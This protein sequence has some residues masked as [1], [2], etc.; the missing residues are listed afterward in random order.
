MPQKG[1]PINTIGKQFSLL[2]K[3]TSAD[4]N[5]QCGYCFYHKRKTDPYKFQGIHRMSDKV[6]ASMI[7]QYLSFAGPYTS[8]SWQG[9][10]P[11]LMGIDFFKKVVE[12]QKMYGYSGQYIGNSVQTNL[13]LIT[14]ELAEL[15][16][17]YNFLV[18]VS[19]DGPQEYHDYYRKNSAKNGSFTKVME[20]IKILQSHNVEF[21]ILAVVNNFTVKKAK[22]TYSFFTENGF[23]FLQ[24]IPAVEFDDRSVATEF[25][26]T[27]EDY[28]NFL[29]QL[30]D[31]WYNKG[32]PIVSIRTFDN[33]ASIYAGIPSEACVFKEECGSYAVIEYNGDV[34]PCDFFVE[35][36]LKLGNLLETPLKQIIQGQKMRKFASNKK[37]I[38]CID[39]KWEYICHSGCQHHRKSGKRDYLCDS[40]KQFFSYSESRFKILGEKIKR[41]YMER[42]SLRQNDSSKSYISTINRNTIGRNDLCP[43]GSGKK[44]K[45]CCMKE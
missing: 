40:Y 14:E 13:T 22:E 36:S 33:I 35:E 4:C 15:F 31:I 2:I 26:V 25:S 17:K 7:S 43:C 9:G 11:L 18:G 30:F 34:Y 32:T 1:R 42:M 19:L 21:N 28:G 12:F 45:K 37:D 8:F 16:H 27:S 10:E 20:G 38:S 41:Q 24:Y 39:C 44:Y 5:L 23:Q 29:C 6:L 3:P